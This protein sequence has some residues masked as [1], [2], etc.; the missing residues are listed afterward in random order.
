MTRRVM[1]MLLAL[2]MA[3][4]PCMGALAEE[5]ELF[6]STGELVLDKG[7]QTDDENT[8]DDVNK[9]NEA[10]LE[11]LGK[12]DWASLAASVAK[13]GDW[14]EDIVAV[15]QTQVGYAEDENGM[16]I[17]TAWSE[18]KEPQAWTTLFVN[19]VTVQAGLTEEDFPRLNS[20][21]AFTAQMKKL[22][23]LKN[24]ARSAYP[25]SGDLA[26]IEKDNQQLV[27][28]VVYVSNGVASVIIGDDNGAVT[29]DTYSVGQTGFKQ[30]IDLDVLMERAGIEVGK[31]GEVPVIPEGGV[32][33]WT[34]TNAVYM[35]SEP[36]TA[37]KRVTT[38][39]KTGTAMIVVSAELQQ[40]GYIWYGVEYGKY[41]GYIRGDLL[42]LDRAAIPTAT[43]VPTATPA[44]T[45]TP[46]PTEVPGC[47][48]CAYEA[49]GVA[50]PVECCYEH[51]ASMG[52]E[53]SYRFM[54]SL[55][56]NDYLTFMLYVNCHNAH[57]YD[58]SKPAVICY[59][60]CEQSIFAP[61]APGVEHSEGCAWY[62]GAEVPEMPAETEDPAVTE[63]PAVTPEPEVTVIPEVPGGDEPDL[64]LQERVVNIVVNQPVNADGT[65]PG[66]EVTFTF[67]VYGATSYQWFQV[68]TK[69]VTEG[70]VKT[71][72]E[73]TTL[74][75]GETGTTL[76]VIAS[77][78]TS[79]RTYFCEATLIPGDLNSIVKSKPAALNVASVIE[80]QAIIGEE[81]Y[82]TY[83]FDGAAKYQ[84]YEM[85]PNAAEYTAL[86][87]ADGAKLS[88]TAELA[89]SGA[90][91]YA[92]AFDKDGK[93]LGK[94]GCYTYEI[95]VYESYDVDSCLT[96]DLC[97]Y[98]NELANMT[99]SERY[100]MMT[101]AWNVDIVPGVNLAETVRQHWLSDKSETDHNYIYATLL[102]TCD[103]LK[104]T[105][106]D[107]DANC[108]WD[109]S[110]TPAKT[111][112]EDVD[113]CDKYVGLMPAEV[114]CAYEVLR[115][116]NPVQQ[117]N[118]LY[119]LWLEAEGNINQDYTQ[120]IS[121][122]MEHTGNGDA[123]IIC[124]CHYM[125]PL[126]PEYTPGAN[127]ETD[128]PWYMT[129]EQLDALNRQNAT[130]YTFGTENNSVQ[131][132]VE[133][134]P[135][136]ESYS[137]SIATVTDE[138]KVA[139]VTS[140]ISAIQPKLTAILAMYDI[141]FLAVDDGA[142]LQPASPVLLTFVAPTTENDL[143]KT[144]FIYHIGDNG[145]ADL[146]DI[147]PVTAVNQQI[148]V[149]AGRFSYYAVATADVDTSTIC[150]Y[151]TTLYA[152][153]LAE[154][155]TCLYEHLASL[156]AVQQ[157]SLLKEMWDAYQA[158]TS[159]LF[160][161]Y[162]NAHNDH[163]VDEKLPPVI[164]YNDSAYCT[165]SIW[166]MPAPGA[167]HSENCPWH[168]EQNLSDRITS[169]PEFAE[170]AQ[171]ATPEMIARALSVKTLN[172]MVFEGNYVYIAREEN[173]RATIDADGYIFDIAT[174]LK[175]ARR[176]NGYIYPIAEDP[177]PVQQ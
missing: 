38:V 69:E 119:Q 105:G 3:M 51:L 74:L 156:N 58:G 125:N 47:I 176:Y 46:V 36:T 80:A 44:P 57:V 177:D 128:C 132:Q 96:H 121:A 99:R 55:L 154:G 33:A 98:V 77:E 162:V 7:D 39:K 127:H 160:E 88:L 82:F 31:G 175:I 135:F 129:A 12:K 157:Y 5:M 111:E 166:D 155:V 102:C 17:Y 94:S 37:S 18:Y 165:L 13:K 97:K 144:L 161:G 124:D 148:S 32:A 56:E 158:G 113:P 86:A 143:H 152:D 22:H 49:D 109:S 141:S 48:R 72:K 114:L 28:I 136:S 117:F 43:P 21:A 150:G 27:G 11:A 85:A 10:L 1:A 120:F 167:E 63:A 24:I 4:L 133:G 142:E 126:Y 104:N 106:E 14:R 174:G 59:T 173:P 168:M 95:P 87:D 130:D 122:Y 149:S 61:V 71:E 84:W 90:L 81:V 115:P 6:I 15:A 29:T 66:Q 45:A 20:Y 107:H 75:V 100:E 40:D 78:E 145:K 92:A 8:L 67:E 23:A 131:V 170:W 64:S 89:K 73:I 118:Y 2:C 116:M 123:A 19:W 172:H 138:T 153:E 134:N 169:E 79:G 35:R 41:T 62:I 147:I 54:S 25:M 30:Y 53:E 137:L 68:E 146:V 52:V 16:T 163:V 70:G 42:E 65:M 140:A 26:L 171:T 139:A 112:R 164:C 108:P 151:Y 60:G 34:N 83:N 110:K 76:T 91:Y 101:G 159:D 103:T 93:E 9:D 50:L